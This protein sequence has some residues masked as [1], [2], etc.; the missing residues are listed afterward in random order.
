MPV[1]PEV[2]RPER[3]A[4]EQCCVF[5]TQRVEEAFGRHFLFWNSE[6]PSRVLPA[7]DGEGPGP[8]WGRE[9]YRSPSGRA[10]LIRVTPL[11]FISPSVGWR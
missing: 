8:G 5:L 3:H 11:S 7:R 10:S 6:I 1:P 4:V 9:T 2:R